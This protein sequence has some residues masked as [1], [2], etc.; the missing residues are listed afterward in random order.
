MALFA[1]EWDEIGPAVFHMKVYGRYGLYVGLDRICF[2]D[3]V[4]FRS[5]SCR[6]SSPLSD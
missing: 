6:A 1:W 4:S 2:S 5:I 3:I